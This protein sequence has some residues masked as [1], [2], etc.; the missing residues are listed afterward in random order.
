MHGYGQWGTTGHKH[1]T[2]DSNWP[3]PILPGSEPVMPMKSSDPDVFTE[4]EPKKKEEEK[5]KDKTFLQLS[6]G[7]D[8]MPTVAEAR[9]QAA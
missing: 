5:P 6:E 2:G 4:P 9:N 1:V 8:D 3:A 7:D